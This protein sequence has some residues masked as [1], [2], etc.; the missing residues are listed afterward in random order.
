MSTGVDLL[1]DEGL[2]K[3]AQEEFKKRIEGREQSLNSLFEDQGPVIA[4][5]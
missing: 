5:W 3:E 4:Y 2:I 1:L